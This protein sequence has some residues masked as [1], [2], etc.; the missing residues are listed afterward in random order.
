MNNH[1][2]LPYGMPKEW[3]ITLHDLIGYQKN[4]RSSYRTLWDAKSMTNQVTWPCGIP[5][6]WTTILFD[7]MS[8]RMQTPLHTYC[9]YKLKKS[10]TTKRATKTKRAT[11]FQPW[12]VKKKSS[13]GQNPQK[14]YGY[15]KGKIRLILKKKLPTGNQKAW[16]FWIN[17]LDI[18]VHVSLYSFT[19][20]HS[21]ESCSYQNCM[22]WI[23][24]TLLQLRKRW[25]S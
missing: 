21:I 18:V 14:K 10:T 12:Y 8:K 7:L 1:L 3:R 5:N 22:S 15:Q 24:N 11:Q 2:T 19:E 25:N 9:G 4:E 16:A 17:R 6:E 13:W 20:A 23:C